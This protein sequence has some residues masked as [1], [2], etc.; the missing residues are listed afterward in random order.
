[1]NVRKNRQ[2]LKPLSAPQMAPSS[3]RSPHTLAQPQPTLAPSPTLASG[4][5]SRPPPFN[6]PHRSA[7]PPPPVASSSKRNEPLSSAEAYAHAHSRRASK[8][9]FEWIT[10]KLTV[11]RRGPAMNEEITHAAR[12]QIPPRNNTA[13]RGRVPA[14]L[15]PVT[16][17]HLSPPH[18]LSPT[19]IFASASPT[20]DNSSFITRAESHSLRSY[21]LSYVTTSERERRRELNNPYPSIPMPPHRAST[22]ESVSVSF[23][24]RSRTPSFRSDGSIRRRSMMDD[25]SSYRPGRGADEDASVRPLPPSHTASLTPSTSMNSR[26]ASASLL[27][28]LHPSSYRPPSPPFYDRAGKAHSTPS[29]TGP[30]ASFTSSDPDGDGENAE[31][32]SRRDST[33]TKPT[34]VLSFDSGPHIAHIATAPSL[35]PAVSAVGAT[36]LPNTTPAAPAVSLLPTPAASPE[37]PPPTSPTTLNR[38]SFPQ[39]LTLVQAPKH[40]HPHP[41]DN[42]HPSSEPEPNASTLTLASSTFGLIPAPGSSWNQ[43]PTSIHRLPLPAVVNRPTS[44]STSPSVTFAADR[45]RPVSVYEYPPSAHGHPSLRAGGWGRMADRD[46]SV[47]AI[48]RKGSWES[49]ESGWSWRAAQAGEAGYGVGRNGVQSP[50]PVGTTTP[51]VGGADM[52]LGGVEEGDGLGV[53]PGTMYTRDSFVTAHTRLSEPGESPGMEEKRFELGPGVLLTA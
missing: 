2:A 46:A 29:S 52:M 35:P 20:R 13:P 15:K 4:T 44:L 9:I 1:L 47:R 32:Q 19:Q 30:D 51:M 27:S 42:P 36:D 37:M 8:P 39:T 10:R 43:G 49:Y 26:S 21:S 16:A 14:L 7:P 25:A 53:G 11:G 5:T 17:S 40:S 41:R 50:A 31:R 22:V 28:P 45:D 48:R 6:T 12:I 38:T 33:S 18:Q 3:P 24:T 23:L 34:T